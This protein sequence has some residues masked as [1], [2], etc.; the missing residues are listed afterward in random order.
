MDIFRINMLKNCNVWLKRQEIN[1]KEAGI[2]TFKNELTA[3]DALDRFTAR[4][5]IL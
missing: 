4:V 5:K 1:E 3:Q 2:G